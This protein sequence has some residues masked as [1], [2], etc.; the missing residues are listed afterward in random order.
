MDICK[1]IAVSKKNFRFAKLTTNPID[2]KCR[3]EGCNNKVSKKHHD[4]YDSC[5]NLIYGY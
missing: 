3:I 2:K 1:L 5:H 4:L